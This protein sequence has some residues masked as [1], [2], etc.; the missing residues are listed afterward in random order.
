[1]G[2]GK[3]VQRELRMPARELRKSIPEVYEGFAKLHE[4]ALADGALDAKT[5]ELIALAISVREGCDGC[6]ASHARG[7]ARA[8]ATRDEAAEAIGVAVLM[9][10]GP[11]TV[12]GPR[13]FA[14]FVEFLEELGR[15]V[16]AA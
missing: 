8:G 5:K 2:Y 16:Q 9:T 12:Y 1:M 3:D 4:A 6:I 7:A 14:A 13:A 11:G 15:P 10:G